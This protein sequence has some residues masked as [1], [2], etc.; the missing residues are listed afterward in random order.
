MWQTDGRT[1]KRT[2][3]CP[4]HSLLHYTY[5]SC[6]K[7]CQTFVMHITYW[8]NV[9][10]KPIRPRKSTM[11]STASKPAPE[12]VHCCLYLK[13]IG[14]YMAKLPPKRFWH[15]RVLDLYLDQNV[16]VLRRH[17]QWT[18]WSFLAVN[19]TI[20]M[21]IWPKN[22]FAIFVSLTFNLSMVTWPSSCPPQD[23]SYFVHQYLSWST[24]VPN[25][26][27]P[28]T[29]EVQNL[30]KLVTWPC[31]CLL[32]GQFIFHWPVLPTI[33]LNTRF[34]MSVFIGSRDRR[35][36]K[37]LRSGSCNPDHGQFLSLANICH[38]PPTYQTRSVYLHL[39]QR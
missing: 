32:M 19:W 11:Q 10:L 15:F 9:Q 2:D 22:N 36:T 3:I 28:V 38:G 14:L 1:N 30:K 16:V 37:I 21:E 7:Y 35:G 39:F 5:A 4:Q 23:S 31:Q 18:F 25:L 20:A 26:K 6:N 13:W 27:V 34:E 29:G 12:L 33:H 8:F 24:N 17:W